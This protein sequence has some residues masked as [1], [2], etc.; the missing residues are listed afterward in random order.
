MPRVEILAV[1]STNDSLK[2]LYPEYPIPSE[3]VEFLGWYEKETGSRNQTRVV[4]MEN[5]MY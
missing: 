3:T 4:I 1:L 5:L 2:D